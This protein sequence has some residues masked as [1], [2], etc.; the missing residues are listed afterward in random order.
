MKDLYTFDHTEQQARET[1]K[2]VQTAYKAFMDELKLPYLVAKADSGNMGGNLS[3]EYHFVSSKGEDNVIS[4]G[5]CGNTI[6]DELAMTPIM[7]DVLHTTDL[8]PQSLQHWFSVSKDRSTL[9]MACF[10]QTTQHG[11]SEPVANQVNLNVV[12]A[13]V[14]DIDTS[15]EDALQVW[16]KANFEDSNS[17]LSSNARI[18]A[19]VDGRLP[20][21]TSYLTQQIQDLNIA[22]EALS[23]NHKQIPAQVDGKPMRLTAT[24]IGD[25]CPACK[26]G[27]VTVSRAIEIGHTFHLGTRYSE[28]LKATVLG[29]TNTQTTVEMGCHGIG[30]SRLVG[31]IAS[32]LADS[33][34][35]NWPAAIAPFQ[36]VVVP[37]KGNE[38]EAETLCHVLRGLEYQDSEEGVDVVLDDRKKAMGWKLNDADLIGYPLILVLGRAWKTERKVEVQCR[39]LGFKEQVA[40]AELGGTVTRLLGRL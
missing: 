11:N 1:Y 18:L 37:A 17:T 5:E 31:A 26:T 7:E 35:L 36:A 9:I 6:N 39:R 13:I 40:E 34:G 27:T 8:A 22:D 29:E 15:V 14:P 38:D 32:I 33:K 16:K 21:G 24:V 4:C 23:E 2:Q 25:Q 12:K 28:P 19:I 30:V 20:L 3:H 10:P